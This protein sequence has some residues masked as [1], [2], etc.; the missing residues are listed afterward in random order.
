MVLF[1][2]VPVQV[3]PENPLQSYREWVGSPR[4]KEA[5]QF[6]RDCIL[7]AL[8][9]R[10]NMPQ[11]VQGLEDLPRTGV[12]LSLMRGTEVRVCMGSFFPYSVTMAEAIQDLARRVTFGDTRTRPLFLSEM[13][14]LSLVLS[15]VGP[16]QE[17]ADPFSIDFATQG[18][19]LSQEG[20]GGV[21]L[22]GETRTLS[23][24][25]QRLRKQLAIDPRSPV[26]FAAFE[27]V[28]F[29]ER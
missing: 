22:P 25:I 28:A 2:Q 3:F 9:P 21:L 24:G 20:R 18:L 23:Y 7:S 14:G 11:A 8:D 12:Y 19:Y 13:T 10:R 16:L 1:V 5:L 4:E 17:V 6:A 26:R 27:V 15:F 29:D